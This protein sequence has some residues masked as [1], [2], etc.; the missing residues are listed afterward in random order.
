MAA[1]LVPCWSSWPSSKKATLRTLK[2][3]FTEQL[4]EKSFVLGARAEAA[5]NNI[6]LLTAS[7]SRLT[8]GRSALTGEEIEE[9]SRIT[10]AV[11]HLHG[12]FGGCG[13]TLWSNTS[14]C[15]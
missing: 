5:A 4:V 11:R 9:A 8:T 3:R 15:P 10:G 12:H 13:A 2:E 1:C 14:G 6:A 7:L